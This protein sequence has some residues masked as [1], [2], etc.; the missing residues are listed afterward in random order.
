MADPSESPIEGSPDPT[1][2][3][4]TLAEAG[5][6][7]GLKPHALRQRIK[8]GSLRG[9]TIPKDG[10][11]VMGLAED[12]LREEFPEAFE[13][14][15]DP[16]GSATDQDPQGSPDPRADPKTGSEGGFP[17][18]SSD[19]I[20]H[21]SPDPLAVSEL[22]KARTRSAM[23]EG[24]NRVLQTR[25]EFSDRER[26]ALL[27]TVKDGQKALAAPVGEGRGS[28]LGPRV[29]VALLVSVVGVCG[30]GMFQWGARGSVRAEGHA[31]GFREGSAVAGDQ[32]AAEARARGQAE[33][34]ADRLARELEAEAARVQALDADLEATR[35]ER[36]RLAQ[37]AL[38]RKVR[39][40]AR[41]GSRALLEALGL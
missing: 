3:T 7:V 24:E 5:R 11:G 36:D 33:T 20:R 22:E 29:S 15:A 10:G 13:P 16:P 2:R 30:W 6:L 28:R 37:D 39:D 32:L 38:N 31:E 26:L 14:K 9:S 12:V 4:Y 41:W 19:P 1:P 8:R 34:E 40:W 35:E 25:L 21:G 23:L 18:R 27:A 17:P